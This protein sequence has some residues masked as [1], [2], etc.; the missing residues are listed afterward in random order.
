MV[1][2]KDQS[3]AVIYVRPEHVSYIGPH[4]GVG[5]FCTIQLISGIAPIIVQG[6]EEEISQKLLS[7]AG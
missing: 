5:R 2:L 3:G 6:S 4:Y 1:E 7:V